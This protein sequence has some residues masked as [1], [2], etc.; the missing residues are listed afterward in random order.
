LPPDAELPPDGD[1]GPSVDASC[2]IDPG[3]YCFVDA[4]YI[5]DPDLSLV[6]FPA[7][8]NFF[9]VAHTVNV[10]NVAY[11][12]AGGRSV[13]AGGPDFA[14]VSAISREPVRT[15]ALSRQTSSRAVASSLKAN[16]GSVVHGNTLQ[17]ASPRFKSRPAD[18]ILGGDRQSL[19][20]VD[21]T[22]ADPAPAADPAAASRAHDAM[23]SQAHST[24]SPIQSSKAIEASQAEYRSVSHLPAS[25]SGEERTRAAEEGAGRTRSESREG[26]EKTG[27]SR[28]G[29][30]S[31]R[32][33]SSSSRG[34]GTRSARTK[35]PESFMDKLKSGISKVS[36]LG[37]KGAGKAGAGKAGAAR[38]APVV[39]KKK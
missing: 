31:R 33:G 36:P 17:V 18:G 29:S 5:G 10:T 1:I 34:E 16:H 21:S 26:E 11:Y 37:A 23:A 25:A 15:L 7:D 6:V 3:D 8:R 22:K 19:Q 2:N 28:S 35:Q 14:K 39:N 27:E 12:G 38:S 30:E 9:Y 4:A 13:Y 32:H 24:V 20:K